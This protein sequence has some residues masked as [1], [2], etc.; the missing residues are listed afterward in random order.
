M[1]EIDYLSSEIIIKNTKKM[2]NRSYLEIF[3]HLR[4]AFVIWSYVLKSHIVQ[5][6][7]YFLSEGECDFALF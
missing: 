2:K 1:L 5:V 6:N 7:L 3:S 4:L